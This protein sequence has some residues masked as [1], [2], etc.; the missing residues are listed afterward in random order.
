MGDGEGLL[1]GGVRGGVGGEGLLEGGAGGGVVAG[2]CREMQ[3]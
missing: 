3:A 2:G 1:E